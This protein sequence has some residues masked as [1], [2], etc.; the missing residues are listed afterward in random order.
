MRPADRWAHRVRTWQAAWREIAT[1][2]D[3][4]RS[5][6]DTDADPLAVQRYA[7]RV[8]TLSGALAGE[9]GPFLASPPEVSGYPAPIGFA[10]STGR[11]VFGVSGTE[12]IL[13]QRVPGEWDTEAAARSMHVAGASDDLGDLKYVLVRAAET[14]L[15]FVEVDGSRLVARG[16]PVPSNLPAGGGAVVFLKV[17]DGYF[18][19]KQRKRAAEESRWTFVNATPDN[20]DAGVDDDP[21]SPAPVSSLLARRMQAAGDGA[22]TRGVTRA[23]VAALQQRYLVGLATDGDVSELRTR[24]NAWALNLFPLLVRARLLRAEAPPDETEGLADLTAHL[25]AVIEALG[26]MHTAY[27]DLSGVL[28]GAP[29]THPEQQAALGAAGRIDGARTRLPTVTLRDK[30]L[31]TLDAVV[32]TRIGYPSGT[33]RQLRLLEVGLAHQLRFRLPWLSRERVGLD[34]TRD[35]LFAPFYQAITALRSGSALPVGTVPLTL[36]AAP[37]ATGARRLGLAGAAPVGLAKLEGGVVRWILGDRPA[38]AVMTVGEVTPSGEGVVRVLPLAVSTALSTP[39][40]RLPGSPGVVGT[41]PSFARL[42]VALTDDDLRRGRFASRPEADGALE[43]VVGLWSSLCLLHGTSAVANALGR[44]FPA[45]PAGFV[46]AALRVSEGG[47]RALVAESA[48]AGA[49]WWDDLDPSRSLFA[50]VGELVLVRARDAAGLQWQSVA[51]V[52]RVRVLSREKAEADP[53]TA[54]PEAP[55]CCGGTGDTVV[56]DLAGL[57]FPEPVEPDTVR[58]GRD[59]RGFGAA[60]LACREILPRQVDPT[61][62]GAAGTEAHRGPEL[63]FALAV[64]DRLLGQ[65]P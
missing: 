40:R 32:D 20:D 7:T 5:A 59:F 25:D 61:W 52:R 9:S 47:T 29:W 10:G 31:E 8:L 63:L 54:P 4:V 24:A 17:D 51:E 55:V 34:A 18:S 26:A 14:P 37:V 12:L 44:A 19:V 62:T 33:L 57:S 11:S 23:E 64:L 58:I 43:Q 46:P 48:L 36:E 21:P 39:R 60:T 6:R 35:L 15:T 42:F 13:S 53:G 41:A 1:F 2:V 30:A 49:A 45:V 56:V 22:S 50:R 28:Y 38:L 16:F 3:R 65:G 27:L